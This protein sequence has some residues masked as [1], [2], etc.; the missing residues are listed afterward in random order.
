MS[1]R[2]PAPSAVAALNTMRAAVDD[3]YDVAIVLCAAIRG[4]LAYQQGSEADVTQDMLEALYQHATSL[5]AALRDVPG[6]AEARWMVMPP[7]AS[8]GGS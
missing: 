4:L 7:S 3:A 6:R 1:A 8:E 2:N 5:E